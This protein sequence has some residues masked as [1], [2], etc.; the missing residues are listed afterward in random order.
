MDDLQSVFIEHIAIIFMADALL[1][2]CSKY[3]SK[4]GE[5]TNIHFTVVLSSIYILITLEAWLTSS[6]NLNSKI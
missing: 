2:H 3:M 5:M 4:L 6:V 1:L